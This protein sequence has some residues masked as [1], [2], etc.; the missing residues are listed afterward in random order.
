MRERKASFWLSY[1]NL[2]KASLKCWLLLK[3]FFDLEEAIDTE[4]WSEAPFLTELSERLFKLDAVR[5]IR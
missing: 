1:W 2:L 5:L 3:D 4:R